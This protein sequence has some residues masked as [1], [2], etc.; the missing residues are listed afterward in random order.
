M[1]EILPRTSGSV[2][3]IKITNTLSNDEEKE[4]LSKADDIV[5]AYGKVS[6]LVVLGEHAGVSYEAATADIKWIMTHMTNIARIAIVTDS[7]LLAVLVDLD[8]TFAKMAGIEEKH[9]DSSELDA[10]WDW[11]EETMPTP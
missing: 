8:A 5:S 1:Y 4:L 11:I 3:G 7:M 6:F 9:F 2:L 10:A